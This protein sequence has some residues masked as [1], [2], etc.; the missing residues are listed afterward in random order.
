MGGS[1]Q[2]ERPYHMLLKLCRGMRLNLL[3]SLLFYLLNHAIIRLAAAV[4]NPK[5]AGT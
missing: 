2:E 1:I 4:A 5:K 3:V